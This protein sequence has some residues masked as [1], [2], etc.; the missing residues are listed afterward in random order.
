MYTLK[1]LEIIDNFLDLDFCRFY[2]NIILKE[3][4]HILTNTSNFNK[5][6]SFYKIYHDPNSFILNRYI[7]EKI[8]KQFNVVNLNTHVNIQ[9]RGMDGEWH[10]DPTDYTFLVM[11]SETGSGNFQIIKDIE[12][13]KI[14]EVEYVQNR[15]VYFEGKYLHRGLAPTQNHKARITVAFRVKIVKENK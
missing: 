11:T 13:N 7:Q 4:P 5:E 1:K 14:T 3:T 12:A 8:E 10:P 9:Y 15:L 6:K 2:N